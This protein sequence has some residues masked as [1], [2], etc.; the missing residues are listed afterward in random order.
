[1]DCIDACMLNAK[2]IIVPC[3]SGISY[4]HISRCVRARGSVSWCT[5]VGVLETMNACG[6]SGN[7]GLLTHLGSV[8]PQ[9]T[10]PSLAFQ[11]PTALV[12][13]HL[14]HSFGGPA[15]VMS[16]NWTMI[17]VH[18]SLAFVEGNVHRCGGPGPN[19]F[20]MQAALAR[21]DAI[22]VN[23]SSTVVRNVD[24][25]DDDEE[26]APGHDHGGVLDSLSPTGQVPLNGARRLIRA[27]MPLSCCRCGCIGY[28]GV[29]QHQYINANKCKSNLAL[30]LTLTLTLVLRLPLAVV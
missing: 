20:A 29:V 5:S 15:A 22:R 30:K 4:V 24:D 18:H 23:A 1:M 10:V 16:R 25:L 28:I 11:K 8:L 26:E 9:R 7:A 6:C 2:H 13:W 27:R 19:P 12:H 14:R 3:L 21:H 17:D